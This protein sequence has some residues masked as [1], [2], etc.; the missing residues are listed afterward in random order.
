MERITIDANDIGAYP[1]GMTITYVMLNDVDD[2]AVYTYPEIISVDVLSWNMLY[3]LNDEAIGALY[4]DL[5][6]MLEEDYN[7]ADYR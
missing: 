2:G 4:D 1:K 3:F 5:N 6:T 7:N